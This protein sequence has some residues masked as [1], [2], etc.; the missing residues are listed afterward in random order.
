MTDGKT[1][2]KLIVVDTWAEEAASGR[3]TTVVSTD[4]VTV[5]IDTLTGP[6]G[7][8]PTLLLVPFVRGEELDRLIEALRAA[9]NYSGAPS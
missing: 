7:E 2:S 8:K 6:R 9:R 5:T 3:Q 4:G 1:A